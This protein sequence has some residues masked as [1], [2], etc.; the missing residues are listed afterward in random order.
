MS[1]F[2]RRTSQSGFTLFELLVSISI[3]GLLIALATVSFSAAQSG[4]RNARR[5][6]DLAAV[7]NAFEQFYTANSSTYPI[8]CDSG[9]AG[10]LSP[11]MQTLP[12]DPSPNNEAYT[13]TCD[14][15]TTYCACALLEG[16]QGGNSGDATCTDPQANGEYYCVQALQ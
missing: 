12:S 14:T 15:G 11:Y 10:D 3:I 1:N 9:L 13:F 4:A 16:G 5:K 6:G 7:R 2:W 8:T